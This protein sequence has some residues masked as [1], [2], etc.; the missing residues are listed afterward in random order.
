MPPRADR[1]SAAATA[2]AEPSDA[3]KPRA[4]GPGARIVLVAPSKPVE[5]DATHRAA[6]RLAELGFVVDIPEGIF[7]RRGYLAGPDPLRARILGRAL[8]DPRADVVLCLAGGYGA[9]RLLPLLDWT[10]LA[11]RDVPPAFIGYSDI[12]ALH[13][14]LQRQLDWVT[15]HGP[16]A[17]TMFGGA[18]PP[19]PFWA[20]QFWGMLGMG[21]AAGAPG[22]P[23]LTLPFADQPLPEVLVPGEATGPLRGGNLSLV[24]A[25]IGTPWELDARG[26]VLFL[27]DVGEEPYRIDRYLSQ[28]ALAGKLAEAAGFV[29][30]TWSA[31][32]AETPER[33]L[34]LREIFADHLGNLGVPVVDGW[35]AGHIAT[36]Q[37][38][39]LGVRMRLTA[40]AGACPRL[41]PLELPFLEP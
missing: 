31:C 1:G 4:A 29:L 14:A 35:P 18:E 6:A 38:L 15:F 22:A 17:A 3:R 32:V 30:G 5:P 37:T 25:T 19:A 41:T 9:T 10:A 24:A 16:M 12:T 21:G 13:L 33:S 39:P 36:Q 8:A 27:E 26:A 28:L 40:P 2:A 34:N 7:E 23:D 20:A 11:A